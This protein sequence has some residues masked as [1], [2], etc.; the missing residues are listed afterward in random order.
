VRSVT[1]VE[2][3]ELGLQV[4]DRLIVRGKVDCDLDEDDRV[5]VVVIDGREVSWAEFGRMV[6]TFEGWQFKLEFCD[7][8]EEL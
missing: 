3:S 5:P 4:T 2:E 8:S 1:H 7:M 6:M